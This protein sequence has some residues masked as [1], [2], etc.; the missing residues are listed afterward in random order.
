MN[1]AGQLADSALPDTQA[2]IAEFV[3][4]IGYSACEVR[5]LRRGA[6][7]AAPPRSRT[8]SGKSKARGKQTGRRD[9]APPRSGGMFRFRMG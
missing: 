3:K 5:L 4:S 1:S 7:A 9:N 2:S 6:F 8:P